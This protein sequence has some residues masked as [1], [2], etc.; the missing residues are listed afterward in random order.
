MGVSRVLLFIKQGLHTQTC[1]RS[2]VRTHSTTHMWDLISFGEV[3]GDLSLQWRYILHQN[4]A[5]P[6]RH[7]PLYGPTGSNIWLS[8]TAD[9]RFFGFFWVRGFGR[10]S[11]REALVLTWF[12]YSHHCEGT[13]PQGK[14]EEETHHCPYTAL[15]GSQIISIKSADFITLA[16]K[17]KKKSNNWPPHFTPPPKR[18][19]L[20]FNSVGLIKV[21]GQTN[22]CGDRISFFYVPAWGKLTFNGLMTS[23]YSFWKG[24]WIVW[25]M[26]IN[27]F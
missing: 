16:E 19:H 26:F 18:W 24:W 3:I 4:D 8:S 20:H 7:E 11:G 27:I 22:M 5:G 9:V 12:N 21:K 15:Q 10:G 14:R 6:L 1:R 13:L 17:R 23:F 25:Q 2:H